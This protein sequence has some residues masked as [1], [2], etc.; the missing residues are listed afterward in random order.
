MGDLGYVL[1]QFFSAK[2]LHARV[3]NEKKIYE[4]FSSKSFDK[5]L[6]EF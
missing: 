1:K 3:L 2:Y 5:N 4:M 6:P